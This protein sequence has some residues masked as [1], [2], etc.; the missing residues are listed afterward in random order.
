MKKL[1]AAS[2]LAFSLLSATTMRRVDVVSRQWPVVTV[3]WFPLGIGLIC[4]A[5]PGAL[6]GCGIVPG[7]VGWLKETTINGVTTYE[8]FPPN[9]HAIN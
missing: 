2:L 7:I 1:I 4:A 9:A 5:F 6:P 3:V 8:V